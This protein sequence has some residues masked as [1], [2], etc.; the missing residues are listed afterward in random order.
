[1]SDMKSD[2]IYGIHA[3]VPG[4][5]MKSILESRVKYHNEKARALEGQLAQLREIDKAMGE[6]AARQGKVSN[7]SPTES[8]ASSIKKHHDQVVYFGFLATHVD[9]TKTYRLG[10]EELLQLGIAPERNGYGY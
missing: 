9:T 2:V 7:A 8:V 4:T 3:D 1:M 5:E 10:K 6:E